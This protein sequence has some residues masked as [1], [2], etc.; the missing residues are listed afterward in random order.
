MSPGRRL[1]DYAHFPLA[2]D[3]RYHGSTILSTDRF[4][5]VTMSRSVAPQAQQLRHSS[6]RRILGWAVAWR[7]VFAGGA[8]GQA[9][10]NGRAAGGGG[11]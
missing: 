6:P 8:A 3:P 2:D 9:G 4:T 11:K 1:I 5:K 7:L 10:V